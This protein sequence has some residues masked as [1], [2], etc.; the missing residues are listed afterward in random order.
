MS[1]TE[2]SNA[3]KQHSMQILI[4]QINKNKL[5]QLCSPENRKT[6]SRCDT[7]RSQAASTTVTPGSSAGDNGRL[8]C[9]RSGMAVYR[10]KSATPPVANVCQGK[11]PWLL[12]PKDNRLLQELSA[13]PLT[14]SF[15]A[16]RFCRHIVKKLKQNVL[17][18]SP[19]CF[20][21]SLPV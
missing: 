4:Y 14:Y 18:Y 15:S 20:S 2:K 9:R 17:H 5:P 12:G 19:D 13:G 11:N 3:S 1:F 10:Q 16:F 7:R 21:L 6:Y 8:Y